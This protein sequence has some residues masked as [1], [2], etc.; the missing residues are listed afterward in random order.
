M[1]YV[2]VTYDKGG[3]NNRVKTVTIICTLLILSFGNFSP[4]A[5]FAFFMVS[6]WWDANIWL[7]W[8]RIEIVTHDVTSLYNKMLVYSHS[9]IFS[10]CEELLGDYHFFHAVAANYVNRFCGSAAITAFRANVFAGTAGLF[11]S[12]PTFGKCTENIQQ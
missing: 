12:S 1:P 11:G 4:L 7:K 5:I 2:I 6:T 8:T 10:V 3:V 9:A